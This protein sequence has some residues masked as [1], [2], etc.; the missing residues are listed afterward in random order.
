MLPNNLILLFQKH[1]FPK[2]RTVRSLNSIDENRLLRRRHPA[3]GTTLRGEMS[4]YLGSASDEN[5]IEGVYFDEYQKKKL[6]SEE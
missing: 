3:W 4:H 6:K 2:Y 5:S 1:N